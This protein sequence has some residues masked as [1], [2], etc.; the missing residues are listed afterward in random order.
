MKTKYLTIDLR[1]MKGIEDAEMLL[2]EGWTI[3]SIG[4]YT[5]QFWK[6]F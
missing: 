4:F 1:T 6:R 2:E 5:I 3:G